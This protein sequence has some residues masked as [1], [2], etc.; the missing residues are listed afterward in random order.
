MTRW[1]P[2][3]AEDSIVDEPPDAFPAD[4]E[5]A[6]ASSVLARQPRFELGVNI[7]ANGRRPVS[8][9]ESTPRMFFFGDSKSF[10]T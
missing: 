8:G 7:A 5:E 6:F 1:C 9:N 2:S 3:V 10:G 4:S